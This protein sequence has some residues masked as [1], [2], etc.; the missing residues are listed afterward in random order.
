VYLNAT[1]AKMSLDDNKSCWTMLPE[2]Y[3]K[4]AVHNVEED[5]VRKG[6]ET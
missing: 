5:L 1:L 4:V 6:K 2:Q 3:V